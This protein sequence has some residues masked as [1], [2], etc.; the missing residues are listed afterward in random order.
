M[1]YWL[2]VKTTPLTRV[3]KNQLSMHMFA[4]YKTA[5]NGN[6]CLWKGTINPF[7]NLVLRC[8]VLGHIAY[9]IASVCCHHGVCAFIF[10]LRLS[11]HSTST[12]VLESPCSNSEAPAFSNM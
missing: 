9:I 4:R 1:E 5:R 6:D 3:Q 12:T 11:S 2:I 10:P 7:R 8:L